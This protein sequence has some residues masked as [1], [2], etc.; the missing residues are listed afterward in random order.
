MKQINKISQE[1]NNKLYPKGN[2]DT[3]LKKGDK[4]PEFCLKTTPDQLVSL[5]DFKGRPVILAF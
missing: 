5:T 3:K 1:E 4:A 2:K